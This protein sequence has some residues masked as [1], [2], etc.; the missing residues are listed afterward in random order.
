VHKLAAAAV[1]SV[2][3]LCCSSPTSYAVDIH[4]AVIVSSSPNL[5]CV[6]ECLQPISW[7]AKFPDADP[8]AIDLMLKMMAFDP[9]KRITVTEALD[10]PWLAQ[11]HDS[12]A[13]P[14]APSEYSKEIAMSNTLHIHLTLLRTSYML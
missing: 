4:L 5:M 14:S 6:D 12:A 2:W 13:E 11:L 10:H 1:Y 9:R 3:R 7:K 8:L